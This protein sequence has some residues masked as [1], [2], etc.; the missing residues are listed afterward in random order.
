[1]WSR[2]RRRLSLLLIDIDHF[3][4]MND[5]FGHLAGDFKLRNLGFNARIHSLEI[6]G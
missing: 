2:H 1:M 6:D 5:T 4:S 3:K